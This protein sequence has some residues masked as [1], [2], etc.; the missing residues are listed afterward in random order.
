MT[1]EILNAKGTTPT[2]YSI[3][4]QD[5]MDWLNKAIIDNN[6]QK[7]IKKRKIL[8]KMEIKNDR[9]GVGKLEEN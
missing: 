7:G 9:R 6:G 3:L 2:D 5:E 1:S 8:K 4:Q